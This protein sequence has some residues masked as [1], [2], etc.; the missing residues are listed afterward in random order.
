MLVNRLLFLSS[1]KIFGTFSS[2]RISLTFFTF[3][4]ADSDITLCYHNNF[5]MEWVTSRVAIPSW[6]ATWYAATIS[7]RHA[8]IWH[9]RPRLFQVGL[10]SPEP[11]IVCV[12]VPKPHLLPHC[13]HPPSAQGLS[14]IQGEGHRGATSHLPL[15]FCPASRLPLLDISTFQTFYSSHQ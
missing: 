15:H 8:G 7:A 2:L 6:S 12:K 4:N 11:S 13:G 9:H 10:G 14:F 5:W 3:P 1:W